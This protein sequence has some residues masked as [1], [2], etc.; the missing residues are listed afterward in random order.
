L[1]W[2]PLI[3]TAW[4]YTQAATRRPRPDSQRSPLVTGRGGVGV[5]AI[6]GIGGRG[7]DI[8]IRMY[9][10]SSSPYLD[11]LPIV[12][13]LIEETDESSSKEAPLLILSA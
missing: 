7:G 4:R 8:I 12:C 6:I 1:W 3:Y 11:S 9:P 2:V 10:P 5:G 13:A